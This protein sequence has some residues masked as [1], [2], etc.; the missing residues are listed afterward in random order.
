MKQLIVLLA[1][2]PLM[3]LFVIQYSSEQDKNSKIGRLQ[4]LVYSSKETAKQEGCF[5]EATISDLKKKISRAFGIEESSVLFEGTTV[6]KYRVNQFDERELIY[7]KVGVPVSKLMA[8]SKLF[9][10]SEAENEMMYVIES[11]TASERLMAQ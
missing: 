11:C 10:I 5:T 7:Y 9:G 4:E 3:L 2:L 6:P 1:V 8:G